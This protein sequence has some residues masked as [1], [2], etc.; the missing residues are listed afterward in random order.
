MKSPKITA[1]VAWIISGVLSLMLA[2][3]VFFGLVK[4][5]MEEFDKQKAFKEQRETVAN[6]LTSEQNR[7]KKVEQDKKDA[8]LNW[9]KF[10]RSLMPRINMTDLWGATQQLW[11]EQINNLGP[12]V[13]KFLMADKSVTIV[14]KSL[15]IAAPP[16]DPNQV[17]KPQPFIYTLGNVRVRGT[18]PAIMRHVRRWN[19]FNR[20]I[21]VDGLSLAGQSPQLEATYTL[22][23]YIF[24]QGTDKPGPAFPWAG[25]GGAGGMMG[26]GGA[27]AMGMGGSGGA[28]IG[29][30]G[31]YGG[32]A[33]G[34][35]PTAGGAPIGSGGGYGSAADG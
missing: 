22:T 34:G 35:G 18:F 27:A 8:E 32:P 16:E 9:A 31:G 33:A 17:N 24:A 4:P 14:E 2:A 20:L 6:Q 13:D 12:N 7:K 19:N 5:S 25:G 26:G 3:G 1:G 30:G 10:D 29:S 28:P 11:R 21:M 15:S 23:A